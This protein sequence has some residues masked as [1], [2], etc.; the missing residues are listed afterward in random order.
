ME[1]LTDERREQIM[2]RCNAATPGP[3]EIEN[4]LRDDRIIYT[5][6]FD[7]PEHICEE[8]SDG[9]AVF[10]AHAR[11]DIPAMD[12]EITALKAENAQLRKRCEAAEGE[13]YQI[14]RIH[15]VLGWRGPKEGEADESN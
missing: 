1:R 7:Y 10:I 9:N 14:G 5:D 2:K 13:L 15:S 8:L 3:W 12:N 11:E 6:A 4:G